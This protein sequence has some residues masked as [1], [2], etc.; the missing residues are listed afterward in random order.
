M[1]DSPQTPN[2]QRQIPH[3]YVEESYSRRPAVLPCSGAGRDQLVRDLLRQVRVYTALIIVPGLSK[4]S[5][6]RGWEPELIPRP[7]LIPR[8]KT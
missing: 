4:R 8:P 2:S 5:P 6:K 7:Q 3:V 1:L